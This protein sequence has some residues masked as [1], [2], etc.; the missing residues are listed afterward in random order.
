[1][2]NSKQASIPTPLEPVKP[3]LIVSIYTQGLAGKLLLAVQMS[4]ETWLIGRKM[5]ASKK[6]FMATRIIVFDIELFIGARYQSITIIEFPRQS[7]CACMHF[8]H[9]DTRIASSLPRMRCHPG[10]AK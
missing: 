5:D 2:S 10:A 9:L 3:H 1:M 6:I 4:D 7:F 8:S